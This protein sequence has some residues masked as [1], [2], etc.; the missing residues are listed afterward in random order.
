MLYML[1]V[2]CYIN[3]NCVPSQQICHHADI[4]SLIRDIL[5]ELMTDLPLTSLL[6]TFLP[7]QSF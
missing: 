3:A 7:L 2:I 1:C 5:S 6:S 4:L